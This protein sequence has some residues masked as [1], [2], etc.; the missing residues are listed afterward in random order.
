MAALV[1]EE[2]EPTGIRCPA[3]LR[4][5]PRIW[6]KLIRDTD[7]TFCN[8]VK[9]MRFMD[10]NLVAG[11]EIGIIEEPGLQLVFGRRLDQINISLVAFLRTEYDELG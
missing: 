2:G 9:Q 8:D 4:D 10:R 1:V 3:N 6:E 7:V 11:F 5:A